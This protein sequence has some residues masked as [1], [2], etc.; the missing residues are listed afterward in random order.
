[1]R[2]ALLEAGARLARRGQLPEAD[3]VFFVRRAELESTL[4][5]DPAPALAVLAAARWSDYQRQLRL[6][7]P[8]V[9]EVAATGSTA[10]SARPSRA[11][12]AGGL[13][14]GLGASGP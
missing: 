1:M 12:G 13:L 7:P 2:Y 10:T 4:A 6:D 5:G 14:R 11:D 9:I 3:R 8:H